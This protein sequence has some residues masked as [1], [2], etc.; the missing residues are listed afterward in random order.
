MDFKD[1]LST[2]NSSSSG[3]DGIGPPGTGYGPIRGR[4]QLV[5]TDPPYNTR[6]E[7]R[8]KDA[9]YDVFE[10]S[11][12]RVA[13]NL[14]RDLLRAGGHVLIF[15]SCQQLPIW[16]DALRACRVGDDGD[17]REGPS[18]APVPSRVKKR[19]RRD[20]G[21]SSAATHRAAPASTHAFIVDDVPLL[22][23]KDPHAFSAG[24]TFSSVVLT[25][26]AEVVVHATRTGLSSSDAHTQ[27]SYRCFGYVPS[28]Y[29]ASANVINNV[30]ALPRAE[31]VLR[32]PSARAGPFLRPEQKVVALLQEL[33]ARFC[34]AGEW[35]ADP[36]C[37][38]LSVAV[39]ALTMRAGQYR[40][41]L[42][43][44]KDAAC[45]TA[46]KGRLVRAFVSAVL[47]GGL[48]EHVDG[49]IVRACRVLAEAALRDDLLSNKSY[50]VQ[51]AHSY[52]TSYAAPFP[53]LPQPV[54][55]HLDLQVPAGQ[56]AHAALSSNVLA[57]L[58]G[59]WATPW[60][61]GI[62]RVGCVSIRRMLCLRVVAL[63]R[64]P[65]ELRCRLQAED[66]TAMRIAEAA[67]LGLAVAP[68]TVDGGAAGL[69]VFVLHDVLPGVQLAP[70]YGALVYCDLSKVRESLSSR[71]AGDVLGVLGTTQVDYTSRAMQVRV[72]KHKW[73]AAAAPIR[74]GSG[75]W[76]THRERGVAV[77]PAP[78]CVGGF[79]NDYRALSPVER[80]IVAVGGGGH[81]VAE[82]VQSR[83]G[84]GGGTGATKH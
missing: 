67:A 3:R 84:G 69:G 36:F 21:S 29:A 22:V 15:C 35:V 12:Y 58:T 68:S 33:I 45:L 24:Q 66:L 1:L 73:R 74:G 46:S 26:K 62:N 54:G 27:V 52:G 4:V 14:F 17:D 16:T 23:I 72:D 76:R 51:S 71:Y 50:L 49:R 20:D 10:D 13:A 32:D 60:D 5:L 18:T 63:D 41:A 28:D 2:H 70:F 47:Q 19:R 9:E 11:D 78:F 75:D 82:M 83:G 40:R 34:H 25:S 8:A 37:G 7:R 79:V 53:S 80:A 81:T 43:S 39:A 56:P 77:R 6:R 42:V 38:T 48:A 31:A 65:L 61:G 55:Y 57:W 44:D 64:W 59:R 30:R